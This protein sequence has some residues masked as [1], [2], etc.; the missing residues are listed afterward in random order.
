MIQRIQTVYLAIALVLCVICT[1]GYVPFG[2]ILPLALVV[3]GI[4]SV[5][6]LLTIFMYKKRTVQRH[7]CRI[8]LIN[9]VAFYAYV[10]VICCRTSWE[11]IPYIY[12]ALPLVAAI[13]V[14][15][16][17]RAI[18]KDDDLVKSADRLR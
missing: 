15:F 18:K 1:I 5:A 11:T 14:A 8:I 3:L 12:S 17:S 10:A 2:A 13:F 16:A 6:I 7:F 9:M 4:M